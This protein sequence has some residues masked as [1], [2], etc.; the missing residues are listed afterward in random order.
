MWQRCNAQAKSGLITHWAQ[1][2]PNLPYYTD[3]SFS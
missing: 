1:V 2:K 3:L